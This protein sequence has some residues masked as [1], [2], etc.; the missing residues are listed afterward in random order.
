MPFKPKMNTMMQRNW[1]LL[2]QKRCVSAT[3]PSGKE[4]QRKDMKGSVD[5]LMRIVMEDG[6][7]WRLKKR[8]H[9]AQI[10][11]DVRHQHKTA[12]HRQ[13]GQQHD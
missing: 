1:R 10:S 7:L 6:G 2:L 12:S 4:Q 9:W 8:G 11:K 13:D 3:N 5:N